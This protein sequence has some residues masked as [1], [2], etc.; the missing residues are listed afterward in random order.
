MVGRLVIEERGLGQA[1][2]I[3]CGRVVVGRR[4][5]QGHGGL[6]LS[7]IDGIVLLIAAS[8]VEAPVVSVGR[9]VISARATGRLGGLAS[10]CT[11]TDG[12]KK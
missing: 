8:P 1:R 11:D 3:G 6:F 4:A 5:K 9:D 12:R 2:R 10:S 7:S